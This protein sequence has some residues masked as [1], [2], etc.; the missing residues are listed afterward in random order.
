MKVCMYICMYVCM[1][2][3]MY[4]KSV[5]LCMYV[6]QLSEMVPAAELGAQKKHHDEVV[7]QLQNQI[8]VQVIIVSM[9]VCM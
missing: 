9:Y 7:A 2:V 1:Y 5:R 6:W 8:T 3:C 4:D